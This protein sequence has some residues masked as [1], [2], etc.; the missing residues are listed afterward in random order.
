M[1][2]SVLLLLCM[3]G[4]FAIMSSTASKSPTLPLYAKHLGLN[5]FEIGLVAAASTITGIFVNFSAGY[6]SDIYGRK[7]LLLVSGFVFMTA[8]FLYL[9]VLNAWEFTAVRVYHGV[10]TAIFVPVA[11]AL[12]ADLYTSEKGKMMGIFSTA[13]TLGRLIAPTLAGVL[14]YAYSFHFTF[15]VCGLLGTMAFALVILLPSGHEAPKINTFRENVPPENAK[16]PID[17]YAIGMLLSVGLVEA[18]TYFAMQG[19][20][21]F[22]PLYSNE[23]VENPWLVGLIFTLQLSIIAA[24]KPLM[25]AL[26]DRVG[27][28][29]VIALG[30]STS[31]LGM[32]VLS[33]SSSVVMVILSIV[34]FATGVSMST[35]ATAPLAAETLGKGSHGTAIGTLETIKD[36]GQALGPI[37]VG[38]IALTTSYGYAFLIAA[39]VEIIALAIILIMFRIMHNKIRQM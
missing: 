36:I 22:L 13:R 9:F 8:P 10:A 15:I 16:D 3:L 5:P 38:F 29:P 17:K 28:L 31:A 26:S 7:K 27:R 21:T 20:E 24:L 39:L 18:S 19:V 23:F 12:V 6:L 37:I 34:I 11:T 30:V 33:L 35:A 14:I 32:V 4:F 25:G 2:V 1:R